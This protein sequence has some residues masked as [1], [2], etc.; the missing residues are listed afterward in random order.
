M[1]FSLRL[2]REWPP[3]IPIRTFHV[4]V[5]LHRRSVAH[6][7]RRCELGRVGSHLLREV[8]VLQYSV[9]QPTNCAVFLDIFKKLL[10]RTACVLG[11]A[12]FRRIS[13]RRLDLSRADSGRLHGLRSF[14][15]RRLGLSRTDRGRLHG[16][17]CLRLRCLRL[18]R[19]DRGRL[20]G[21]RGLFLRGLRLR[22]FGL[23]GFNLVPL[24]YRSP[25]IGGTNHAI[26]AGTGDLAEVDSVLLREYSGLRRHLLLGGR[27]FAVRRRRGLSVW[28]SGLL[29]DE[30]IH[31][32]R[33]GVELIERPYFPDVRSH[34]EVGG[35]VLHELLYSLLLCLR[36][37]L[38]REHLR[39]VFLTDDVLVALCGLDVG[40]PHRRRLERVV[41][42]EQRHV[43]HD[44]RPQ[45][46]TRSAPA[47]LLEQRVDALVGQR[48]GRGVLTNGEVCGNEDGRSA[49]DRNELARRSRPFRRL[50][51]DTETLR[52][53]QIDICS[54]G[55]AYQV[56]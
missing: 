7:Q 25:H 41:G 12:H 3:Y 46:S 17:R 56:H 49:I 48:S 44:L 40:F 5:R 42:L 39:G 55:A 16:L 18:S 51:C 27:A 14:L 47:V 26:L 52:V 6:Q 15:L 21:L 23:G 34:R 22:G 38:M 9:H 20:H 33:C 2:S 11:P 13:L 1:V 19:T 45:L 54:C 43:G 31:R 28:R 10:Q 30:L 53:Q 24:L 4:R 32:L 37:V 36:A 35:V 50:Q 8:F 29:L